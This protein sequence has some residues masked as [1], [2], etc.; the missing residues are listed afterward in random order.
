MI[1]L[2]GAKLTK[3][4]A[5]VSV[6]IPARN[7]ADT[8]ERCLRSICEQTYK[9]LEILVWDDCSG[10]NTFDIAKHFGDPRI[11]AHRGE[12]WG[13]PAYARNRLMDIA[14]GD[15]IAW[16]DADDVSHPQRL[17][18]QL[19]A[20]VAARAGL[21]YVSKQ[22]FKEEGEIPH[23]H[24]DAITLNCLGGGGT[25]PSAVIVA[26]PRIP[27][28]EFMLMRHEYVWARLAGYVFSRIIVMDQL[29]FYSAEPRPA[30]YALAHKDQEHNL[31]DFAL[32]ASAVRRFCGYGEKLV[33]KA[34]R[35]T[36]KALAKLGIQYRGDQI[37]VQ[38]QRI[39]GKMKRC[40]DPGFIQTHMFQRM[41]SK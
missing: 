39:E 30:R 26:R 11:S 9:N 5:L 28:C 2:P 6:I 32:Q 24:Y 1:R 41:D 29:Y 36:E 15:F 20:M 14:S 18:Y 27:L 31:Y 38:S 35:H 33:A 10:D 19:I 8:I 21:C 23:L 4:D 17:E 37:A 13:A 7:N 3:S 25:I 34:A 16:Q 22:Y 12:H 40:P